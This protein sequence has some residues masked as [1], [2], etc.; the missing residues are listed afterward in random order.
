MSML[1]NLKATIAKHGSIARTNRFKVDFSGMTKNEIATL[2]EIRDLE[3]FLEDVNIPGKD[4]E[5]IDYSAYR[6]PIAYATGYKYG[7]FNMKFRAPTN[8]FV[9]TIFD[10]WIELIIPSQEYKL[11]YRKENT[12]NFKITQESER[13]T[14]HDKYLGVKYYSVEILDAYPISISS[15]EYSNSQEGEYVTFDVSFGFR[16]VKYFPEGEVIL[17][18]MQNVSP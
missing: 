6:N 8:M 13:T 15:I 4:I 17:Q 14:E 12:V 16:D 1:T 9:K 3:Y 7:D 5:T 2:D 11:S 18:P 10:Y